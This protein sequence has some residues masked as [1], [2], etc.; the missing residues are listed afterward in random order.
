MLDSFSPYT[1]TARR[2]D[3][4]VVGRDMIHRRARLSSA[5]S[6]TYTGSSRELSSKAMRAMKKSAVCKRQR[7]WLCSAENSSWPIRTHDMLGLR[8]PHQ[9]TRV[10]LGDLP[11]N[12]IGCFRGARVYR[13]TRG[14]VQRRAPTRGVRPNRLFEKS[15]RNT[16]SVCCQGSVRALE[17]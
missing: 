11:S 15:Y 10:H 2:M 3:G 4:A 5:R 14:E 7:S 12:N 8:G 16:N 17:R 13:S 9:R 1:I 6:N